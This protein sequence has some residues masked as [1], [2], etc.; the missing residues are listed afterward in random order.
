[1]PGVSSQQ[2]QKPAVRSA[3]YSHPR[4]IFPTPRPIPSHLLE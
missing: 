3:E 4:A 2:V 1:M